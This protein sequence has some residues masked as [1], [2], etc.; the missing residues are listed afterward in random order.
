[1]SDQV[2]LDGRGCACG[3]SF[4]QLTSVE[5]RAEE[6]LR[7]PG[8]EGIV[9]VHPNVFYAAL[10]DAPVT[11]WQVIQRQDGLDVLL[12]GL[13]LDADLRALRERI[14]LGLAAAGAVGTPV[15]ILPVHE[16]QRTALGKAPLVKALKQ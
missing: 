11:G 5:G 1:M 14:L 9:S 12:A 15:R 8:V 6:T 3:R 10:E 2:R 4:I 16:I 7:L 13:P